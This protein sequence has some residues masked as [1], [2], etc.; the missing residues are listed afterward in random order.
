M[1]AVTLN[2]VKLDKSWFID[3][4]CKHL[5]DLRLIRETSAFIDKYADG[6]RHIV[7]QLKDGDSPLA[8]M[9]LTKGPTE[10]EGCVYHLGKQEIWLSD[11]IKTIF[12]EF[13]DVLAITW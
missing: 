12:G 3:V 5:E 4:P 13:P 1:T 7:I 11:I 8:K 9:I 10:P 2:L 6:K